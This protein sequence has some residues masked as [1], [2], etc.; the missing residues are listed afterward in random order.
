MIMRRALNCAD[1]RLCGGHAAAQSWRGARIRAACIVVQPRL[2]SFSNHLTFAFSAS[3]SWRDCCRAVDVDRPDQPSA[4]PRVEDAG[5]CHDTGFIAA[6]VWLVSCGVGSNYR[7]GPLRLRLISEIGSRRCVGD[8]AR[9]DVGAL[10]RPVPRTTPAGPN[11]GD[12]HQPEKRSIAR[13]AIWRCPG[14][15]CRTP[16]SDR[17]SICISNMWPWTRRIRSFWRCS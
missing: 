9:R 5:S 3:H 8:L 10:N 1:R 4:R 6:L 2:T 15:P 14:E 17:C 11:G 13:R 12:G 7:R 16:R